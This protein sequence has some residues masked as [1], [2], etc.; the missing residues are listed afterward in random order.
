MKKELQ[1]YKIG[2]FVGGS[3]AWCKRRWM[4]FGGCAAITLCEF[5]IYMSIFKNKNY[6]PFD[7][8][9]ISI[10]DYVDFTEIARPYLKPRHRGI[11]SLGVYI[12]GFKKYFDDIGENDLYIEGISGDES[13]ER[14]R[15]AI[16][17]RIDNGIIIPYLMLKH[18]SPK[19]S[20]YVWHWFIVAGY[21]QK[22][23]T[24]MIKT[25]TYGTVRWFDLKELWDTGYEKKGGI[26]VIK[27]VNSN[28][29]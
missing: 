7:K 10:D 22:N 6:Y 29:D 24:F 21:E 25:I 28:Q 26:V 27:Y 11:D 2:R 19:F 20:D 12:A 17:D 1:Y 23:D 8:N 18:K 9:N 13:Y 15:N 3:Q 14:A 5:C 4:Y 16:K